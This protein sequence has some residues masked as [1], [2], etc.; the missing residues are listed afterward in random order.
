ML[1][2]TIFLNVTRKK[3]KED[4]KLSASQYLLRRC[5]F[6]SLFFLA[7]FDATLSIAFMSLVLLQDDFIFFLIAI[8][9]AFFYMISAFISSELLSSTHICE[10][11][12]SGKEIKS[13][14]LSSARSP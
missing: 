12:L 8:P 9:A 11:K 7:L 14:G 5:G 1:T 4:T 10:M 3:F 2:G 13:G 6:V